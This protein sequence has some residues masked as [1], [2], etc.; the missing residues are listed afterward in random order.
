MLK[1]LRERYS[2]A[3]IEW[4]LTN[5]SDLPTFQAG[6]FNHCTRAPALVGLWKIGLAKIPQCDCLGE[7]PSLESHHLHAVNMVKY[8]VWFQLEILT[9]YGKFRVNFPEYFQGNL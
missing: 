4:P 8:M 2:I 5:L 7:I 3:H 1:S 6:S 9:N